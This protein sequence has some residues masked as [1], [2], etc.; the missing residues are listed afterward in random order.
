MA[1]LRHWMMRY[2]SQWMMKFHFSRFSNEKLQRRQVPRGKTWRA[3]QQKLGETM[4]FDSVFHEFSEFPLL[5]FDSGPQKMRC[6]CH[7]FRASS[8]E[9]ARGDSTGPHET[10]L[11]L[12]KR[13]DDPSVEDISIDRCFMGMYNVCMYNVCI[14]S[15][16]VNIYIYIRIHMHTY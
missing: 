3:C 5:L 14:C 15:I 7:S 11:V 13:W 1:Q 4:E 9:T 12:Q 8:A 2:S 6:T 10:K 16:H